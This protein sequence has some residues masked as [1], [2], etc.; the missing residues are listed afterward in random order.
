M[1]DS[2]SNLSDSTSRPAGHFETTLWTVVLQAGSAETTQSRAALEHLCRAYWHPL[3]CYVRRRGH[4]PP[5]AQDLV[6][7]F[8][9][10]LIASN[11][12]QKLSPDKGRFRAFL[13]AAM[14]YF[15]SGDYDRRN[16]AKRGSGIVPLSL[17][18]P[19]AEERYLQAHTSTLSPEKEF[20]RRWAMA[21]LERALNALAADQ[22][23]AGKQKLFDKLQPFLTDTTGKS[24]YAQVAAELQMATNALAVTV[25]RLRQRYQ[26]LVRAE[27]AETVGASGDV[28][29]EMGELLAA[30][31]G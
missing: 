7:G 11:P 6:Q 28:D 21:V 27:V 16:A 4:S 8:F 5:D 20:D 25:H 22:A 15:L 30:M 18:E 29:A 2:S 23:A 10:E 26:Q 31:R 1:P 14:N 3:Y 12:F 13:L 19:I 17:D 24:D 9:A